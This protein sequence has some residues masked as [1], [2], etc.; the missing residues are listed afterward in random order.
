VRA[1]K[2]DTNTFK[3]GTDEGKFESTALPVLSHHNFRTSSS[4]SEHS[5]GQTCLRAST[6]AK[7]MQN[8]EKLMRGYQRLYGPH[9]GQ[10]NHEE[11]EN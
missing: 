11:R 9:A 5:S 6:K 10:I 8:N 4:G 2:K 3:Q 1:E 7:Q